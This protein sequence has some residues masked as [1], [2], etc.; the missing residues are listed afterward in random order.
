[1]L[2]ENKMPILLYHKIDKKRKSVWYVTPKIFEKQ[3]KSLKGK[4]IVYL[5]EYD[6]M[7][8]NNFVITFDGV[9]KDILKYAAPI[10]KK[11]N[12][13]FELF[14]T[15]NY[16]G[17]DN[18]F[19]S[20]EPLEYFANE[21]ELKQLM[22]LGGRLQWHTNSHRKFD[23]NLSLNDVEYEC[24]IPK[25][26]LNLDIN[27]NGFKWF[28]YPHGELTSDKISII[29]KYFRGG[30]SCYQGDNKD[31]YQLNRIMCFESTKFKNY[32]YDYFKILL[33]SIFSVKN[34]DKYYKVLTFLG[35]KIKIKR[36]NK[37]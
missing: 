35:I 4:R 37:Q 32:Y 25:N 29:K 33:E 5:D 1:M 22:N 3:M 19:D 21:Q 10:L 7:D 2:K 31:I 9:Y 17:K 16:I 24:Q 18:S 14:I 15:G 8:E 27:K 30:V 36:R 28:A 13:P 6:P 26:I 34:K 11:L 23:S 12:Y 20:S